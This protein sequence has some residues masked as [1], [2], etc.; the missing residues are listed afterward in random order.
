MAQFDYALE[1]RRKA[2]LLPLLHFSAGVNSI[3]VLRKF[4]SNKVV[5]IKWLSFIGIM[6][7]KCR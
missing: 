6:E 1:K 5:T 4:S 7:Y 2:F 3:S